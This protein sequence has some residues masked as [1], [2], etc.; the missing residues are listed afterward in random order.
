M[1]RNIVSDSVI[2]GIARTKNLALNPIPS[3][4]VFFSIFL[5]YTLI[6]LFLEVY[7]T[8]ILW[9]C[10]W[11]CSFFGMLKG[12]LFLY[13]RSVH[14]SAFLWEASANLHIFIK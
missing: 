2:K 11:E 7:G 1:I 14:D 10:F 12:M 9:A 13:I 4:F 8:K 3:M 6:A 5:L